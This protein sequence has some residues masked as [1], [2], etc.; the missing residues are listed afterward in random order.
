MIFLPSAAG[1]SFATFAIFF[2]AIAT[3]MI[4][5]ILF[6]GSMNMPVLQNEIV[7]LAEKNGRSGKRPQQGSAM[8]VGVQF[9]IPISVVS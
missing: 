3:S 2:T 9:M 6:R 5:L 8:H 4:P 7:L 1:M